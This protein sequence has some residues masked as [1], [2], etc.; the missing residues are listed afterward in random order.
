MNIGKENETIEFKKSTSEIKAGLDSISAI[1]NK[2]GKGVLYFGVKD[3]GEICGQQIGKETEVND[4]LEYAQ[5]RILVCQRVIDTCNSAIANEAD[6]YNA[7]ADLRTKTL[8]AK[9][10][11]DNLLNQSLRPLADTYK[12]YVIYYKNHINYLPSLDPMS[13]A[14]MMELVRRYH[15]VASIDNSGDDYLFQEDPTYASLVAQLSNYNKYFKWLSDM[16]Y[17]EGGAGTGTEQ[18]VIEFDKTVE[19]WE[20]LKTFTQ[21]YDNNDINNLGLIQKTVKQIS[22]IEEEIAVLEKIANQDIETEFDAPTYIDKIKDALAS[23]LFTLGLVY[24][25]KVGRRYG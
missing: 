9:T 1:L 14:T 5:R 20:E 24:L 3:N 22:E 6:A 18:L 4:L 7:Y 21:Y 11:R 19:L 2:H 25:N 8:N 10:L 16:E 12:Q 15:S 17:G 23:Y 13:S